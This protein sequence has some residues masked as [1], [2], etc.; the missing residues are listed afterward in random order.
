VLVNG[1]TFALGLLTGASL[2]RKDFR[3]DRDSYEDKVRNWHSVS[4]N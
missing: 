2:R 1:L 3:H 4:K